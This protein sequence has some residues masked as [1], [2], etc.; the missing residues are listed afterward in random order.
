MNYATDL[1]RSNIFDGTFD[2]YIGFEENKRANIQAAAVG[3]TI[4]AKF[5]AFRKNDRQPS[6]S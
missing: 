5:R 4:R 1:S 2:F 6:S 3:P